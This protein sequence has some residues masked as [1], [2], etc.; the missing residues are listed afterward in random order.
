[1]ANVELS[2]EILKGISVYA[3]KMLH[4]VKLVLNTGHHE[5]RPELSN[6]LAAVASASGN[7]VFEER[8]ISELVKGPI[9][10]LIET[11]K[12]PTGVSFSG[13][14]SGHEFNSLILAILQ[15][16]GVEIKLDQG[17]QS[18][19]KNID[20]TL[21]FEVFVSLSCQNCPEVV[22]ALNEFA[23]LNKNI[24][25]EMIDG[26]LF[27]EIIQ[28]RKI[29][30][31]PS[32]YLNGELFANGRVET[33]TL[34]EKLQSFSNTQ[35][36]DNSTTIETQDVVIAG[37]GPAGIS[38]AIYA[39]RKGFKVTLIAQTIGGQLKDTM[40]I[41]NFI[42]VPKTTGPELSKALQNHMNSYGI[43]IKQNL[44]V[45]SI[46]NN[47][48]KR[49]I[50]TSGEI[51][52]SKTLIIA[53]GAQ[54]RKLNLP[55]EEE[56]IGNGVAYC[57]HCD[58]PFFKGKDV[59]VIGGGNSGLEASIDLSGI[60]NS[61]TVFEFLDE[62]KADQVLIDRAG[63]RDNIKIKTGVETTQIIS[64]GNGVSG[65]EYRER[66]SGDIHTQSL[67]GI[68]VQ[69]GLVPNSSFIG[70]VV[71]T[72]PYGEIIIDDSGNTSAKGIFACGD[73]TTV[74]HKQIIISMGDGAKAAIAAADYLQS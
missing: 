54:W 72:N 61:V 10:F 69:I 25:S 35:S 31:V 58:G 12:G 67:S 38:A 15:S 28:E 21:N 48:L 23:L 29:S 17:L 9:S 30:G 18:I 32:V 64:S 65:I 74:P 6:F 26:G 5:R 24:T 50:L 8:D 59:A 14:P 47:D 66:G 13:I 60:A 4:E 53:T 20:K 2:E 7:I 1:M 19:I 52:E 22:Q 36:I 49:I 16:G 37:G 56:N 73:V 34:I 42:S 27:Q 57:P 11:D 68:F 43:T 3:G 39:A 51:I 33:A 45:S 44:S 63:T 71:E 40:G 55:G 70:N 62:L 41:E 46:E